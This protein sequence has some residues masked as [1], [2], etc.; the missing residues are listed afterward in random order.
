M[1]GKRVV[2]DQR[3]KLEWE[4]RASPRQLTADAGAEKENEE[5]EKG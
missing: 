2:N 5:S 1:G 3:G 4:F